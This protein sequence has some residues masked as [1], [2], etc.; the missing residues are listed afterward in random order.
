M[1]IQYV[2]ALTKLVFNTFYMT[3]FPIL[4]N[5]FECLVEEDAVYLMIYHTVLHWD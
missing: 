2:N 3:H 1:R 4:Q 5:C